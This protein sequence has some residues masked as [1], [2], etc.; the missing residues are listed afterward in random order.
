[1]NLRCQVSTVAGV[2]GKI[3]GQRCRGMRADSATN[4]KRCFVADPAR[5]LAAQ[6]RVLMSRHEQFG[7]LGS[8]TAQHYCRHGQQP[9]GHLV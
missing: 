5:D 8:V 3:S 1:M 9:Q 4:Q 2:M 7:V 6:D